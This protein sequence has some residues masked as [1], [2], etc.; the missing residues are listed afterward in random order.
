MIRRLLPW[1]AVAAVAS[2]SLI[3]FVWLVLARQVEERV[4]AMAEIRRAEGYS[5]TWQNLDIGGFP[6]YFELGFGEI[7]RAHV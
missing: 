7:G 1:L 5:L 4:L 6:F 2:A 3:F